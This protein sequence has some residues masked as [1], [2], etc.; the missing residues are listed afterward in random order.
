MIQ[1]LPVPAN[2]LGESPFWHAHERCLYWIDIPAQ[3]VWRYDPATQRMQHFDLPSEP[4]AIAPVLYNGMATPQLIV[5]LRTGIYMLY[6]T[7]GLLA[8]LLDAP[9]DT[10]KFRFNDGVCD[11]QGRL[12]AGAMYEP[13]DQELG[14][15]WCITHHHG[16]CTAQQQ[17]QGNITTNGLAFSL[18]QRTLYWAHTRAHRVDCFAVDPAHG[19]LSN[20]RVFKQFDLQT[21]GAPYGG[22]PDGAAVDAQGNYWCALYEGGAIAQLS[23]AG[24]ELQRIA[25]PV[26]K[27]T[28]LCFGGDDLKTLYITSAYSDEPWAGRVLQLQVDTPGLPVQWFKMQD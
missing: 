20:R 13:R 15:L 11:A 21:Q 10:S 12:W 8:K 26:S 25:V 18:D 19:T 1:P 7:S 28:M 27:P 4:G 5:A 3:H 22:R 6:T 9:Y 23:P 17:A 16:Q 24:V 14:A 2:Q